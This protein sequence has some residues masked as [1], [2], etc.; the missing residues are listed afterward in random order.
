MTH[1]FLALAHAAMGRIAA[2]VSTAPVGLQGEQRINPLAPGSMRSRSFTL[3]LRLHSGSPAIITG[4]AR[5][6]CTICGYDTQAGEGIA[7]TSPGPN[8]VK[9]A[10]NSDCLE[11][12]ETTMWSAL[13]GRP[14]ESSER[15]VAAAARSSRI[16]SFAE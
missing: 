9:Q 7:T 3:A 4:R 2:W 10:L 5:A 12:F 1:T 6:R 16:P 11:P 14:P 15:C 8:S 13:T